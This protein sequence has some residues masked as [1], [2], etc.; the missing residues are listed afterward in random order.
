[1][2]RLTAAKRS[3]GATGTEAAP[4]LA[5]GRQLPKIRDA[6]YKANELRG[7]LAPKADLA[8]ASNRRQGQS[9]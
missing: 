6:K 8:I 7:N 9:P 3:L 2:L 1:V 5:R 4:G